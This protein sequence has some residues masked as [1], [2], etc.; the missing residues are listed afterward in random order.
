MSTQ[1]E[2]HS[3][4]LTVKEAANLLALRPE[5]VYRLIH[6]GVLPAFQLC[7][8]HSA[9]RIDEAELREWLESQ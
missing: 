7:G 6:A 9:I 4:L 1:V 5:T 8:K 3:R 2:S